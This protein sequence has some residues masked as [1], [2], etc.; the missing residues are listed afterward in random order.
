MYLSP[1]KYIE[2]INFMPNLIKLRRQEQ[3]K[4]FVYGCDFERQEPIKFE[5]YFV[6][7][8]PSYINKVLVCRMYYVFN[9]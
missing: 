4:F 8:H 2:I 3:C 1:Q 6:S 5:E 9:I 7:G